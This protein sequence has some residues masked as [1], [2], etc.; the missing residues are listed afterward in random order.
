MAFSADVLYSFLGPDI[1]PDRVHI[2]TKHLDYGRGPTASA[3]DC[4]LVIVLTH[5]LQRLEASASLVVDQHRREPVA[6]RK[7]GKKVPGGFPAGLCCAGSPGVVPPEGIEPS[8]MVPETIILSVEL[9]RHLLCKGKI[10]LIHRK[11]YL[12]EEST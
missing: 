5:D 12:Q 7:T 6:D 2:F 1:P 9:R 10:F 11:D 4:Y 8:S 3:Y